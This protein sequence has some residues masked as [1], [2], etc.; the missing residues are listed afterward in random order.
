MHLILKFTASDGI[1]WSED[2]LLC[3][4]ADSPDALFEQIKMV[5]RECCLRKEYEIR[6][7]GREIDVNIRHL[8]L[9]EAIRDI[10]KD[11]DLAL[12]LDAKDV[13]CEI[14][15]LEDWF[16]RNVQTQQKDGGI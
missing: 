7:N 14:L 13:F 5:I 3:F 1:I 10:M 2:R 6:W 12:A 16:L 4:E 9:Q 8:L 11:P 15:S